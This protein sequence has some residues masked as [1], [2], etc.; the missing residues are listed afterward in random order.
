[1]VSSQ[2][3]TLPNGGSYGTRA[4]PTAR[5]TIPPFTVDQLEQLLPAHSTAPGTRVRFSVLILDCEGC[6][7]DFVREQ[8]AFL[9]SESLTQIYLEM[10]GRAAGAEWSAYEA[11]LVPALCAFG[12]DV[13]DWVPNLT[14][15][16]EHLANYPIAHIVFQ[17]VASSSSKCGDPTRL[18][19]R[20][21]IQTAPSTLAAFRNAV[22]GID[23]S[24][25]N[26]ARPAWLIDG[27]SWPSG[28]AALSMAG[29]R[30]LDHTS[31]LL[32]FAVADNVAGHFIETGV[33]RGGMSFLAAKTLEL[34]EESGASSGRGM[35][36]VY[37]CDSFAGI[38]EQISY[39][40]G[41]RHSRVGSEGAEQDARAHT[42][43]VLNANSASRVR[44]DATRLGLRL[45]RLVF[46]PGFFNASL[47]RLMRSEPNLQFAVIRLD[48]DTYW[49][50]Y[51]ALEALYPRL[52]P[53]GFVVIDD[54]VDWAGCRAAVDD[55]RKEN[56]VI[57]PV[58]LVPHRATELT[59]G[60]Y[61]RKPRSDEAATVVAATRPLCVGAPAG[62]LRAVG[63]YNPATA[64]P[65][66]PP[67]AEYSDTNVPMARSDWPKYQLWKCVDVPDAAMA[68][69]VLS[70]GYAGARSGQAQVR[71]GEHARAYPRAASRAKAVVPTGKQTGLLACLLAGG[72][73]NQENQ[74]GN[75]I[76]IASALNRRLVLPRPLVRSVADCQHS[77]CRLD[78]S[79]GAA[80]LDT[81]DSLSSPF[82]QLWDVDSFR[83]CAF[84]TQHVSLVADHKAD[85]AV[86]GME[87]NLTW[88]R[89]DPRVNW[90]VTR[91]RSSSANGGSGGRRARPHRAHILS[92]AK[93]HAGLHVPEMRM[94]EASETL[95]RLVPPSVDLV[96]APEPY[97]ALTSALEPEATCCTPSQR[98]LSRVAAVR[99]TLPRSYA[100]LHARA[101]SDWFNYC[102][103]LHEWPNATVSLEGERE[104]KRSLGRRR[105]TFD[106]WARTG[107]I[108]TS[109]ACALLRPPPAH[110]CYASPSQMAATMRRE[111]SLPLGAVVYVASGVPDAMLSE[112]SR[113]YE[114]RRQPAPPEGSRTALR[115]YE[116]ALVDRE[117][118]RQAPLPLFAH[119]R[120]TYSMVLSRMREK[121]GGAATVWYI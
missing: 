39:G 115:T 22:L 82:Q 49:S 87:L 70:G 6:A 83:D 50:T 5:G 104:R 61:W 95:R 33:W 118:C 36:R 43:S 10:D 79:D 23:P 58:T 100:C 68:T 25:A 91:F 80:S 35:R 98:L 13:L 93:P 31:A 78:R 101:E 37:L 3:G 27:S 90:T 16:Q 105:A 109:P 88:A 86:L 45:E 1:V 26:T 66:G 46:V 2:P 44:L 21:L 4:M 81:P 11:E 72:L 76:L 64:T 84:R 40:S 19:S 17:R 85:T 89:G 117:V 108:G 34:L 112:V 110:T 54:Y 65:A 53:G 51:E 29:Q 92:V 24:S 20:G 42:H 113:W 47:P 15:R 63:S 102:C 18:S 106:E 59:R 67:G 41:R 111:P 62:Q 9:R 48:G 74:V 107:A 94:A 32:A 56:A 14:G 97:F 28:S 121:L 55:Y 103:S 119:S 71:R 75:C 12:F 114:T 120:S 73:T 30:R 99:A 116:E 38:P 69:G 77:W 52:A 60:A 96:V 8:A 7:F 57:A